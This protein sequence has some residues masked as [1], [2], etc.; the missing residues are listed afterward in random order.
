MKTVR[1]FA[2]EEQ[3]AEVYSQK[4]QQVYKLNRKEAA[5]YT[6]YVWGSGVRAPGPGEG[7][8]TGTDVKVGSL[9]RDVSW[10][11]AGVAGHLPMTFPIPACCLCTGTLSR[12]ERSLRVSVPTGISLP[13]H[14]GSSRALFSA[15]GAPCQGR[16]HPKASRDP[17]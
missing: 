5:A 1:S 12:K 13:L 9:A 11:P 14:V 4:L 16:S 7:P 10:V 15:R 6:Y 8:T 17:A 2:N 3:E